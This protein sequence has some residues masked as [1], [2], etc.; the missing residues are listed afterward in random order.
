MKAW[1][2]GEIRDGSTACLSLNDHGLLYGDGVFEGIRV[3]GGRVFLLAEH[4]DRLYECA[5][6]IRLEIR[7]GV[8][9][10][11]FPRPPTKIRMHHPS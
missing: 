7:M 3:Y 4:I 10:L 2:R 1:W 5:R 6:A 11:L 9:H 8:D